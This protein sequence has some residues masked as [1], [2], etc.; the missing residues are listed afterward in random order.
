MR[1][2]MTHWAVVAAFVAVPLVFHSADA[3]AQ[4]ENKVVREADRTVFK[5]KTVIDFSDLT[6]QGELTKPEG[7]YLLNRKK[8]SFQTL[9]KIRGNFLPELINSTDNL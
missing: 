1:R 2:G 3:R 5:K 9:L 8:T 4:A 6:I 7:S